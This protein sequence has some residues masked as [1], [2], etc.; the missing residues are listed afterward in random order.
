MKAFITKHQLNQILFSIRVEYDCFGTH[1][2]DGEITF[3]SIPEHSNIPIPTPRSIIPFKK[4]LMPNNNEVA[5]DTGS[6]RKN[7][8]L[9]GIT[10]CDVEALEIL[11]QKFA[12]TTLLP[13]REKLLI[14]STQC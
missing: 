3:G 9:I 8:A 1:E 12:H 6:K 11:Y 7:I 2:I 13:A 10:N 4:I 5:T 14:V